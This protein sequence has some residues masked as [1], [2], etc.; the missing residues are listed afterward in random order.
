MATT[1]TSIQELYADI[2]GDLIPF[3]ENAV[4]LPNGQLISNIYNI[5]G[6]SG[7]T[8]KIPVTNAWTAG[9]TVGEGNSII[10][11]STQDFDPTSVSLTIAKR[12]A[13]TYVT[14]ES[15]EDGGVAVVRSAVLTRLSRSIA[16]ATDQAGFNRML[17]GNTDAA[18]TDI[19]AITG[20][21]NDGLANTA[22]TTA[23]VSV[24]FS[25]EAMAYGVKRDPSLKMFNDVDSDRY[26]MV[27]TVRNGF[28]RVH[29]TFIR[30]VVASSDI[31]A[32]AN[33]KATLNMFST[34]VANLRSV[35]APTDASGFYIAVVTPAHEYHLAAQ[36]NGIGG[37][38]SGSIGDLSMVGNQA[39]IDG[40]IGQ[41]IGCRFVRSNNLP[42]G[43]ASV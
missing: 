35:N 21:S 19:S 3:Y 15:L 39:L 32:D 28:A 6:T 41:A 42:R 16:Q 23:D 36:L 30:A 37:L 10:S 25:P 18:L 34:S 8:I 1:S 12:G 43:I 40:L 11:A 5:S 17:Q 7:N 29:P 38:S 22:V 31:S 27:A 24:V 14:E 13:G 9:A 26:E 2:V 4:L 20:V 33:T